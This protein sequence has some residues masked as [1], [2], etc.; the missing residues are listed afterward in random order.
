METVGEE[1]GGMNWEN[2]METY[3]V[4]TESQWKFVVRYREFKLGTLWQW[5]GWNW[6][7]GGRKIQEGGGICIPMPDSCWY[8]AE[9]NKIL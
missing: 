3:N 6:L 7:G 1:E 8:T 4:K 5:T 9:T 2:S